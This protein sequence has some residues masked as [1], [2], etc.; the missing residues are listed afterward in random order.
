MGNMRNKYLTL[1]FEYFLLISYNLKQNHKKFF[2]ICS[3]KQF[4]SSTKEISSIIF[5]KS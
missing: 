4:K 3:L 1:Y 5:N 2:I